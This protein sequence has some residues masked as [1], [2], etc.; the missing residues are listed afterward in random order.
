MAREID[1][2]PPLKRFLESRGYEVKGEVGACDALAV[3]GDEAPLVVEL[4][5]TLSLDL[6]LQAVERLALSPSV[7]IGVPLDCPSLRP[8]Q[9][10]RVLRL[11]RRLGIG[12]L[13]IGTIRSA[14]VVEVLLDPGAGT[15]PRQPAKRARL[16]AEF[17]LRRGDPVPGGADRR[18]GLLT[19]YRQQALRIAA[20]IKRDGPAKASVVA[21]ATGVARA[22]SILYDNVYGWFERV[23]TGIYALS[24]RGR[25]ELP[26]WSGALDDDSAG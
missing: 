21:S 8:R 19:A 14:G 25:R 24:E 10:R 15:A 16:L 13:A 20:R 1:L 4:K 26:D 12:L 7:Y 9:R 5:R 3:R 17:R 2:Y 23:S 22:R 11:L 6:L 18:R